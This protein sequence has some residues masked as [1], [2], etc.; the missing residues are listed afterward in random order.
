MTCEWIIRQKRA[1]R[2]YFQCKYA[3]QLYY[4]IFK[5]LA[6][7]YSV[8]LT[9]SY[10]MMQVRHIQSEYGKIRTRKNSVFG[11]FSHSVS[12]KKTSKLPFPNQ[13]QVTFP[14][15]VLLSFEKILTDTMPS[16]VVCVRENKLKPNI[17]SVLSHCELWCEKFLISL[18]LYSG[19]FF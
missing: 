8:Y 10:Q 6:S 16:P 13:V 1:N 18:L 4:S 9:D 19:F 12:T 11:H 15:W 7:S 2:I 14:N 3:I 17:S 5:L